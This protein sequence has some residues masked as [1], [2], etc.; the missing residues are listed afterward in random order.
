[1]P[2][3]LQAGLQH[4]AQLTGSPNSGASTGASGFVSSIFNDTV[5]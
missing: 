2:K 5:Y 1:M 4:I 3:C